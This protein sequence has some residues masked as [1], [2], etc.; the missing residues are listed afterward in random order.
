MGKWMWPGVAGVV[1]CAQELFAETPPST[2]FTY[3][4]VLEQGEAPTSGDGFAVRGTIGQPDASIV[5]AIGGSFALSGGFWFSATPAPCPGDL[6]GD[7]TVGAPDLAI[8]L[9]LWGPC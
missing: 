2:A 7:G 1:S 3:Q 9:G 4:G 5:P 8:L 6:A